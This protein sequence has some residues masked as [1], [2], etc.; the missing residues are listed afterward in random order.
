MLR[1][2]RIAV[3][4]VARALF[5]AENAIDQ[6]LSK[7]AGLTSLMPTVRQQAGLS[8]IIGQDAVERAGQAILALTEARRAIV[9]T[10]KELTVAQHQIGMGTVL[11]GA[12]GGTK[13]FAS[14]GETNEPVRRLRPIR[15]A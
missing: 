9:E 3:E 2:R 13:P 1:E 6:A 7:A 15:A 12:G 11:D 4:Q 14:G 8:A 10:H 5:E